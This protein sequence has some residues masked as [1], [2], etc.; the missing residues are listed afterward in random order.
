MAAQ[1][2]TLADAL[3]VRDLRQ[4]PSFGHTDT[5]GEA[6]RRAGLDP[7]ATVDALDDGNVKHSTRTATDEAHALRVRGIPTVVVDGQ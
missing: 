2:D 6:A 4:L 7:I 3:R 1:A 5:I